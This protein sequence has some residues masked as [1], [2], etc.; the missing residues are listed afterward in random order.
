MNIATFRRDGI[1]RVAMMNLPR[2]DGVRYVVSWQLPDGDVP[3]QL[4]RD[5]VK[6]FRLSLPGVSRNRNNALDCSTADLCLLADD[7]LLYTPEQL[8][9]VIATFERDPET[10]LAAFRYD[11][12]SRKPY[13][14]TV[15]DISRGFPKNHG[16]VTT[17]EMAFRRRPVVD[18][19]VRFCEL[20]GPGA[21]VLQAAEDE[22]FLESVRRKGLRCVYYPF[23]V[24]RHCGGLP[25]GARRLTAGVVKAGGA[26]IAV[27]HPW[28][29]ALRIPLWAWRRWRRGQFPLLSGML[30]LTHGAL[31]AL[32]HRLP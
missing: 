32:I 3:D 18:A 8:K 11:P 19:G 29:A 27:T 4:L 5:D 12:P 30:H 28:T 16:G 2:V 1:R 6:V 26:V 24:C 21:P 17:I 10:V 14:A 9:E 23:T 31:Y 25:T 15:T 22:L 20:A 7:D 13:P